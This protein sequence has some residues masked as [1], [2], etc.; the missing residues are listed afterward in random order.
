MITIVVPCFNEEAVLSLLHDRLS[1]S[2]E[3]WTESY[4][5]ILVDDGSSDSTWE[6]LCQFH[7][8]DP[9]WKALRLARNFGHQKAVSAGLACSRGDCV[10]IIDADLQDPPEEIHR[11]IDKWKE[12]YEV[13]YAVRKGRKEGIAKKICYKLFYRF[14]GCLSDVKIPYDSG[15]FC[16]MDSKVVNLINMMPERDRF[17]RGMRAWVGFRQTGIEYERDTRAAGKAKYSFR[18]LRELAFSGIYSFSV[19][20]LQI[21]TFL[22]VLFSGIGLVGFVAILVRSIFGEWFSSLGIEAFSGTQIVILTGL[23]LGGIQLICLGVIG[24]YIGRIYTEVKR[25][26][27]WTSSDSIGIGAETLDRSVPERFLDSKI[28][29]SA[30]TF[31][32]K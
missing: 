26:P 10:V 15:D 3:D 14:L 5:V 12:G 11:F 16:L 31:S 21:S 18:K 23:F 20:P 24:E 32:A 2:A 28:G 30:S 19:V 17:V 8:R 9:R 6:I 13:V 29:D 1:A 4:E 22:G 27:L 7:K 25:R